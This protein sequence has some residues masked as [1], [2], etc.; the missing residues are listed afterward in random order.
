MSSARECP[1]SVS[2]DERAPLGKDNAALEQFIIQCDEV[3]PS[4]IIGH[5]D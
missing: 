1:I 3:R 4:F 2:D 5:D